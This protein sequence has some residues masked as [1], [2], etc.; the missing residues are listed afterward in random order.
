[1][2]Y[3][4]KS[5][6]PL[7]DEQ[8]EQI[9]GRAKIILTSLLSG[10]RVAGVVGPY[11]RMTGAIN[12]G[13]LAIHDD[14]GLKYGVAIVKPFVETR[15]DFTMSKWELD[16]IDRGA[17][18]TN[19]DP[20]DAAVRRAALFE[21]KVLYYGLPDAGI[22]GLLD[23]T[24]HPVLEFGNTPEEVL[25]S[26]S[27]AI[28]LIKDS[29]GKTPY[30]LVVGEE[31]WMQINSFEGFYSFSEK[32]SELLPGGVYVSKAMKDEAV[33]VP[34]DDDN[35]EF[36]IGEDFGIGYQD[37]DDKNIKL[38]VT[39]RFTFRVLDKTLVVVFK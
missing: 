7:S 30:S 20:L 9:D 15:I 6:A 35:I 3:L 38:F 36:D 37:D 21:E 19:W 24:A 10:R 29:Y 32:V 11:G 16:S 22:V 14:D 33:M 23:S 34:Y 5:A 18:D 27:K 8:W 31:K 12:E 25:K 13:R 26:I 1:M 17:M 39:E 2:D 28:L 4:K